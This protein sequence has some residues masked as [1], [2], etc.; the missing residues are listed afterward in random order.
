M[1]GLRA[2]RSNDRWGWEGADSRQVPVEKSKSKLQSGFILTETHS[3]RKDFQRSRIWL[4]ALESLRR[5]WRVSPAVFPKVLVTRQFW[6]VL[7]CTMKW[8]SW[9]MQMTMTF[10]SSIFRC[11]G[12]SFASLVLRLLNGTS[13]FL[14][15]PWNIGCLQ[16]R[17]CHCV[18]SVRGKSRI[19][20]KMFGQ[21]N[22]RESSNC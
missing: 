9:W 6:C 3:K 10:I 13:Q 7:G 12:S 2:V 18:V 11:W 15:L 4:W 1:L 22:D 20:L 19:L 17:D 14:E 16:D 5:D 8:N 21:I